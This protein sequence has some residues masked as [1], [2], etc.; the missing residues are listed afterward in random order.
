MALYLGGR[1]IA[2]AVATSLNPCGSKTTPVYI[3][4]DYNAHE[5]DV[6]LYPTAKNIQVAGTDG[7]GQLVERCQTAN[8]LWYVDANKRLV[9]SAMANN[10]NKFVVI[11]AN[12]NGIAYRNAPPAS[13]TLIGTDANR[14]F[15]TSPLNLKPNATTEPNNCYALGWNAHAWQH[16]QFVYGSATGTPGCYRDTTQA[17][18]NSGNAQ[19]LGMSGWNFVGRNIPRSKKL[20][21]TDGSGNFVDASGAIETGDVASALDPR[22]SWEW[23]PYHK[24]S[25]LSWTNW[26]TGKTISKGTFAYLVS[27]P[28]LTVYRQTADEGGEYV[29]TLYLPTAWRD[30]QKTTRMLLLDLCQQDDDGFHIYLTIPNPYPSMKSIAS[31]RLHLSL[32]HSGNDRASFHSIFPIK[33]D[34]QMAVQ[35]KSKGYPHHM[36]SALGN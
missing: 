32:V 8:A 28:N 7:N 15:I 24:T 16:R 6:P 5:C 10:Q 30:S 27:C 29:Y 36:H 13:A 23:F 1:L 3:G 14:N 11:N 9:A 35:W 26:S 31:T 18:V 34:P 20:I 22:T 21:G 17:E 12:A 19:F 4:Q 25:D 33:G 2:G